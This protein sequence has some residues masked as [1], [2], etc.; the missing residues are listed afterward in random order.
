ML[1]A[2]MYGGEREGERKREYEEAFAEGLATRYHHILQ[3]RTS[4][5]VNSRFVHGYNYA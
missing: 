4:V 3:T 2:E 5:L 1:R